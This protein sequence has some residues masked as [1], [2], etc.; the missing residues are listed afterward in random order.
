MI[1]DKI[2][3]I[4]LYKN[5]PQPVTEFVKNLKTDIK[6][7]RYEICDGIYANV[8]EYYTKNSA[9][10]RFEKHRNYI[11]I[12]ILL[13]GR[14]NIFYTQSQF[15]KVSVPYDKNKDIE[16]YSDDINSAPKIMLDGTN[17]MVIFPHELHAPQAKVQA[18]EK[19]LKVVVKIRI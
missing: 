5:I 9:D 10:C 17:F 12:Q 6:L 4:S 1:T 7:G 3:N 13:R 18:S 11:D 14:E 2:E 15:C 8:E 19:V 16:F